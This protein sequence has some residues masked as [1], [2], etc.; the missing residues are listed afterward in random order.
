MATAGSLTRYEFT[1]NGK[2]YS[3]WSKPDALDG[4]VGG[5]TLGTQSTPVNIL[6]PVG[7]YTRK[8]YP[9]QAA[10]S[11]VAGHN[12]RRLVG[13][14]AKLKTLPGENA[15]V[16]VEV[17]GPLGTKTEVTTISTNAP[18]I[19]LHAF[20]TG[21]ASTALV[22]RSAAGKPWTIADATP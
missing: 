1:V 17:S 12:R 16:E 11:S 2:T 9:G 21:N 7:G 20:F 13:D 6:V 19:D 5:L 4:L 18:F 22:L 8:A 14:A 15:Y 10:T 3:L